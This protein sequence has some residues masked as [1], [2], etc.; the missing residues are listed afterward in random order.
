MLLFSPG[1][2]A[3]GSLDHDLQGWAQFTL[4][5]PL[6]PKVQGYIEVQPRF[7]EDLSQG[8]IAILRPAIGYQLTEKFSVWQGYAYIP[9]LSS[10]FND[11][12]RIFQ[13]GLL[14]HQAGQLDLTHR[15][16]FEERFIENTDSTS[17]RLRHLL[18]VTY[19]LGKQKK[20]YLASSDE[21]FFNM[22]SVG[23]GPNAGFD[24]N[25]AFVGI[26]RKLK[27]HLQVEAGYMNNFLNRQ[28]PVADRLNHVIF[29]GIY[30]N[31]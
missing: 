21:V 12:H 1:S 11:E 26:G 24:Q 29:L 30:A 9:A 20:W 17:F 6:S 22:N 31:Y 16:R 23:S 2:R 3:E 28:D 13:Q 27:Q 5:G 25:R 4:Q 7:G 18:R 10:S 14:R 8:Q 15:T 19:P